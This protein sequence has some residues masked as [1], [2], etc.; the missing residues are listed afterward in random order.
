MAV[1]HVL[2]DMHGTL[3]DG[4]RLTPAMARET[5]RLLAARYGG[6]PQMWADAYR[7]IVA[8]WD[9]YM[10]DLD[11]G[12]DDGIAQMWEARYRT[13]RASFRRANMP[14]P[15]QE[16]LWQL[17]RELPVQAA[18][19]CTDAIYP[20]AVQALPMLHA[21]GYVLGA[22]AQTPAKLAAAEL[23]GGGVRQYFAAVIGA[24]STG[25]F[26]KD[27]GYFAFAA[28]Q[29]G[30]APQCC[31]VVDNTLDGIHGA[32]DAGMQTV[33]LCRGSVPPGAR[34]A[35][36]VLHGASAPLLGLLAWLRELGH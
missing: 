1:T 11:F 33:L 32:A 20:D 5:G 15:T 13:T 19:G 3:V 30:A 27:A 18:V 24:D 25:R 35:G 28:R 26:H 4:A 17:A 21:Q 23:T 6:D 14:E 31:V 22:F 10:T 16:E 7:R 2:L 36:H 12:A 9:S 8:D 34:A 29:L